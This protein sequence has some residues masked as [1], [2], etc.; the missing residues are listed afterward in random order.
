[1]SPQSVKYI[2]ADQFESYK[3]A[4]IPQDASETQVRET[5]RAFYA[6][7]EA[8][9]TICHYV[10]QDSVSEDKAQ[11]ILVDADQELREFSK[12]VLEGRM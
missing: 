10:G 7:A 12:A 1:M 8:M 4:A 2:I 11:N 3:T 5:R 9:M 6:G